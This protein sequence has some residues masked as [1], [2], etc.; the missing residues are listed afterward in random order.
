MFACSFE[1]AQGEG[2]TLKATGR[3]AHSAAYVEGICAGRFSMV[4]NLPTTLRF[5]AN[6]PVAGAL[7]LL[8]RT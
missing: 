1:T 2:F 7:L 3:F 8:R 5:E 6:R 4:A